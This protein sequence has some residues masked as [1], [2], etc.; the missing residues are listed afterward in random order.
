MTLNDRMILNSSGK[1]GIGFNFNYTMNSQSTDLVIGDGGGGRGITLW[2]AAAADNQTI[3]FQ[4]N[5][6]LS[7]AEGEISYGPTAT[8]TTADRNAMMFRVNSAERMRIHSNGQV[9]KPNQAMLSM[10]VNSSI[11][12]GNYLIHDSVITNN[13]NHYNTGNGRFTCPVA[14]FYYA[15]MMVMSNNSSTTMDFELHKNSNNFNN[16]LVPYQADTGGSYN[17]VS[18][19]CIIQCSANDILQFKLNSGSVYNGRHSNITFAL[20]A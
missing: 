5:E 3:S 15:S 2:T 9:T 4:T 8:S 13:G 1:L 14:G 12:S 7:R 20:L 18:G 11:Q 16:I 10:T 17:Q 6:S 19:S